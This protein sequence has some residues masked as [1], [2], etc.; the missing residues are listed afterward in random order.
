MLETALEHVAHAIDLVGIAIVLWGFATSLVQL[1]A[2]HV[3]HRKDLE[4][5]KQIQ[6]LR[7]RLGTYLL[8]ALEFMIASDVIMTVMDPT[9]DEL[10]LIGALVAI[11]T[12]IGFFLGKELQEVASESVAP[13]L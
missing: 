5:F 6:K 2:I 1:V 7:C 8:L 11:R 13:A 4:F 12:A 3:K 10:I 9:Y